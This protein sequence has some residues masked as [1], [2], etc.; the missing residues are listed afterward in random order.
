MTPV[1]LLSV[2]LALVILTPSAY[3]EHEQ[4][5]VGEMRE[6]D[7]ATDL[8]VSTSGMCVPSHDREKLACYFSTFNL[9]KEKTAEQI[10]KRR[11]QHEE[12]M[13]AV[14][15]EP[16]KETQEWKK[17]LCSEPTFPSRVKA[18]AAAQAELI[19][20]QAFC[21]K[22]TT[23][24]LRR[25]FRAQ[26]ERDARTCRCT[27]TDWR[28]SFERHGDRWVSKEGPSL[29]CG[30]IK[31]FTLIPRDINGIKEFSGPV[32]WTLQ[33]TSVMTRDDGGI[34]DQF[35][36]DAGKTFTSSWNAPLNS[37][38]CSEYDFNAILEGYRAN[39]FRAR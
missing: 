4:F 28:A 8:I 18:N 20:T 36:K 32:L 27:V 19:A 24:S 16:V 10:A 15:K 30:V 25:I 38:D 21:D 1:A 5:V 12:V 37:L 22:P 34:C 33:E 35:K 3:A 39:V 9:F 13:E 17:V 26:I 14:N 31:V 29:L 6:V 2:A 11:K 23:D 7:P